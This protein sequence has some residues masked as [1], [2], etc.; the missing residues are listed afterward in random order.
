MQNRYNDQL[1][2]GNQ[3]IINLEPSNL[4]HKIEA[5]FEIKKLLGN[6]HKVLEIGIGEGDFTKYI[7]KN[8]EDLSIDAL[9]ISIEMIG[10]AKEV[11][12]QYLGRV[13]FICR[14]SLEYLNNQSIK[15]D[16]I[17]SSWTIHNF[18]WEHKNE[19]FRAIYKN[20]NNDGKLII[21]DKIYP[22]DKKEQMKLLEIQ[23]NRYKKYIGD[24]LKDIISHEEQDYQEVYRMAESQT[25]E[26]LKAVGF[27][28]VIVLDRIERDIILIASK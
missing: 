23:L 3:A 19:L 2:I 22:D 24:T 8:N 7:L 5:S 28:K 11:L 9:D 13:S 4:V 25:V 18:K 6:K 27:S 26:A 12:S 16:I 10:V 15:Y 1:R 20:L 14:D 21:I 17:A